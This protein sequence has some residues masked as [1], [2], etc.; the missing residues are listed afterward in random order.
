[1]SSLPY[2]FK[3]DIFEGPLDLLLFLIKEQ[4]MDIYDIPI[5]EITRQYMAYLDLMSEMNLDIAGEYLIMAAELTRIKSKTLLPRSPDEEEEESEG[6]DPRD[7]LVQRLLEYQ[8]F[9]EAAFELRR[10]EYDRQQVF[11]RRG[12]L[13]P[14]GEEEFAPGG[15]NVF[16]LLV[17]F[18]KFV[19]AKPLKEE[20]EL[21]VTT[22]SVADRLDNILEILNSSESVTFE[23][24][25]TV[26]NTKQ[27]MIVTFLAVLELIRLKLVRVEQ[28]GHFETIRM[29]LCAAR[30]EQEEAVRLYR[31]SSDA[32]EA[33]PESAP[34]PEF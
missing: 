3:L 11:T 33:N 14:E 2:Q 7:L 13:M 31:E 22:L 18:Q 16:D 30:E 23:S 5:V 24:M 21:K 12:A 20:Y 28:A 6:E 10:K 8:R 17:A 4:K 9:K 26:L 32:V 29:Y 34:D 19:Q 27:E 25:F 1:M 15:A